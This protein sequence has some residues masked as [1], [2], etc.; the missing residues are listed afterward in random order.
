MNILVLTPDYPSYTFSAGT[1]R[2]AHM[3]D[4]LSRN[5]NVTC[6]VLSTVSGHYIDGNYGSKISLIHIPSVT[7]FAKHCLNQFYD[8]IVF[9]Y[10][11]TGHQHAWVSRI[12]S[13][14]SLLVVDCV[15]LEYVRLSR[16][17][18]YSIQH[19]AQTR[20][21]ET[22]LIQYCDA[23]ICVSPGEAEIVTRELSKPDDL[24]TTFSVIYDIRRLEH[25]PQLGLLLFVGNGGHMPNLDAMTWFCNEVMPHVNPLVRLRLVGANWPE[26]LNSKNVDVIGF[27]DDIGA[28][29][30]KCSYVVS[31]IRFGSG[32]N[33]KVAEAYCCGLP[34]IM[35]PLAADGCGI[36]QGDGLTILSTD[37]ALEWVQEI[38]RLV[39]T[40][41]YTTV[42]V[43][44]TVA[45]QFSYVSN[46]DRLSEFT[47]R[48]KGLRV[49]KIRR[50]RST[51]LYTLKFIV[52]HIRHLIRQK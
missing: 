22:L 26:S 29:Y 39:S 7:S 27:V 20:R 51:V 30:A 18:E 2:L 25:Q 5:H 31:P 14:R 9:E 36:C 49:H 15:D 28:E 12:I 10:W 21:E 37:N 34:M 44:E 35:S 16:S 1:K 46:A 50:W 19:I 40:E 11:R 48:L 24:V 45:D 4:A 33:G 8:V 3:L 17:A 47:S 38:N 43:S 23:V 52:A 32:V 13:P 42:T 41:S 6:G